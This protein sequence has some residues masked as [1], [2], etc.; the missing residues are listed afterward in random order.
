MPPE[1]MPPGSQTGQQDHELPHDDSSV[2]AT[3]VVRCADTT[4]TAYKPWQHATVS[5]LWLSVEL[6]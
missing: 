1:K 2:K 5:M 4:C 6:K 3:G